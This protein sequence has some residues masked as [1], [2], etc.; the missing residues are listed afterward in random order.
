[1]SLVKNFLQ[2]TI[3]LFICGLVSIV[4]LEIAHGVP[5]DWGYNIGITNIQLVT[6]F[7]AKIWTNCWN[8][9]NNEPTF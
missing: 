2:A 4:T 9:N 1:M 7:Y 3:A 6:L 5:E 8:P